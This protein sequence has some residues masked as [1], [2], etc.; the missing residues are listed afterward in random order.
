MRLTFVALLVTAAYAP[1]VCSLTGEN[2]GLCD[3]TNGL[4]Y[5]ELINHFLTGEVP[6]EI[7][8]LTH[9]LELK[10]SLN[11][12][13][14]TLPSEIGN[15]SKLR[16]LSLWKNSL[17]GTIPTEVGRF[18]QPYFRSF[19]LAYNYFS[20]SVPSQM[21]QMSN[22]LDML[23]EDNDISGTVPTELGGLLGCRDLYLQRN[24]ISGTVPTQMI[25]LRR[26]EEFS[27]MRGDKMGVPNRVEL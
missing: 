11:S 22:V 4:E 19:N 14:G 17:S 12:L 2:A 3:G 27:F 16:Y 1:D 6:S 15:L 23:L 8:L 10:F 7:G 18:T 9:V 20:G 26:L 5:V 21:G 13:T 25:Y 24:W